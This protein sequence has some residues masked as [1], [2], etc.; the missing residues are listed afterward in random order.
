MS[1]DLDH[2]GLTVLQ[3]GTFASLKSLAYVFLA[4]NQLTHVGA[5]SLAFVSTALKVVSLS[6]NAIKS[7]DG[8]SGLG[9]ETGVFLDSNN[10]SE[11]P[12][13][14]WRPWLERGVKVWVLGNPLASCCELTWA[15]RNET[16]RSLMITDEICID[17]AENFSL[18]QNGYCE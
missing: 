13:M 4:G 16:L 14:I 7:V 1:L 10:L 9:T 15:L 18:I 3:P 5:D 11:M 6:H 2:T 12:E 17:E 8:I